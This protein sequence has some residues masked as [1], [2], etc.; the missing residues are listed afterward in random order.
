MKKHRN[1]RAFLP[2]DGIRYLYIILTYLHIE[3]I[4]I[5]RERFSFSSKQNK[6]KSPPTTS[7]RGMI[8]LQIPIINLII[9]DIVIPV[10]TFPLS[11][12]L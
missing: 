9:N 7:T 1:G 6:N 10:T 11:I 3:T 8:C 2:P 4:L 5:I 12:T